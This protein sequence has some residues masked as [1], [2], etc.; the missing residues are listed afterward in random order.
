MAVDPSA[1]AWLRATLASDAT[2]G[3]GVLPSWIRPLSEDFRV[4]GRATTATVARDDS[5]TFRQATERGPDPG[6]V[7]VIGGARSSRRACMGDYVAKQILARGFAAV[8][9]DGLV[10]DARDIRAVGL[11]VWAR[12]VSPIASKKDGGGQV[13]GPVLIGDVLI[14]PGDWVIA[15]DNGVVVWPQA[16]FEVLLERARERLAFDAERERRLID[17][18]EPPAS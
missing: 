2:D 16:Q 6:T 9:T 5:L 3:E 18:L 15:D 4:V 1:L 12:G 10:R 7:L 8:V 17:S 13:G 14:H 11:P